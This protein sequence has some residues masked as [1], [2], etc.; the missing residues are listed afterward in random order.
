MSGLIWGSIF[1]LIGV[2]IIFHLPFFRVAIGLLLIYWGISFIMGGSSWRCP[3]HTTLFSEQTVKSEDIRKEYNVV[4]GK[5][6]ID[7]SGITADQPRK[8][9]LTT[10]FGQSVIKVNPAVPM[11]IEVN[12]AFAGANM[13][14]GTVMAFGK[15][16]YKTPAYNATANAVNVEA[17]VVF[18]A[19]D[20]IN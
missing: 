2:S 17:T 18:G 15:Y 13:P 3:S 10:V 8:I 9:K 14:D 1:V 20:I 12:S 5:S 4:F 7:L 11:K 19:M 6:M 16:E